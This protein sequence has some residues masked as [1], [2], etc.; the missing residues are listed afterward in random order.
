MWRLVAGVSGARDR[1]AEFVPQQVT[2]Q[3]LLTR[4]D[5]A[6][7]LLVDLAPRIGSAELEAIRERPER[8]PHSALHWLVTNYGH[9]REHLAHIELTL[10]LYRAHSTQ[11]R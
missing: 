8:N 9:A 2:K 4:L 5:A 3:H 7:A 6:D 1:D 11:S 10:Q